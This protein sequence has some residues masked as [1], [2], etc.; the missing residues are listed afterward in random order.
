[1]AP[2]EMGA[3]VRARLCQVAYD[4]T[5]IRLGPEKQTLLSSR[6][7]K[8]LRVL[9][10]PDFDTYLDYFEA[11]AEELQEFVNV[12]T[13][14]TTAFWREP[15]HFVLLTHHLRQW[16]AAGQT[17]FRIWCGA[18]S[19]GQEPYTIALTVLPLVRE[20][21]IDLKIL[22]T[23]IDTRVLAK[24]R[25]GVFSAESLAGVP[26]ELRAS[27]FRAVTD[28]WEVSRDARE[29][30][31]FAQLNLTRFPYPMAGPMDVVFLRNVMIY[32]DAETRGRMVTE[33]T[34]MLGPE[35]YLFIGHSESLN[36]LG[37]T[38]EVV[39]PSVYRK[40]RKAS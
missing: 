33:I 21:R 22:A 35:R 24:A 30:V 38:L 19:T 15:D 31:R 1:M 16:V 36:G 17:R 18:A 23:D 2:P 6:V 13:T 34:R 32:L 37:H 14:N 12:I 9:G 8:R 20:R 3:R 5:G 4:E 40:P 26:P 29:L 25:R 10:L 28:G 27:E 7:Q 39:R 11:H